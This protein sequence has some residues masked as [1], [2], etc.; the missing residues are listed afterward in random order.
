MLQFKQVCPPPRGHYGKQELI[1]NSNPC[2]ACSNAGLFVVHKF[3]DIVNVG[4]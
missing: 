3:K 1:A 2:K 4:I